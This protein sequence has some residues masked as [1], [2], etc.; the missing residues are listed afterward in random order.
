MM[1]F[2]PGKRFPGFYRMRRRGYSIY[3]DPGV[4]TSLIPTDMKAFAPRLG[5]AWDPSRNGTL[6]VTAA[7]G[8]FCM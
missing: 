7:Y 4:P 5:V 2:E 8:I 6:L 1:I 3:G